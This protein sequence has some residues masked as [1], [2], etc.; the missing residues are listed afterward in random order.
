MMAIRIFQKAAHVG[1]NLMVDST[2]L[3]PAFAVK[4]KSFKKRYGILYKILYEF[5]LIPPSHMC[6]L[7]ISHLQMHKGMARV[8]NSTCSF[9]VLSISLFVFVS[10]SSGK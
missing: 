8:Y 2:F 5:K 7:C 10:S 3:F 4:T 9:K 6:I 1:H